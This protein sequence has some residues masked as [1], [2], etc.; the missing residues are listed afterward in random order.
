MR[1]H[2]SA[3]LLVSLWLSACGAGPP[4]AADVPAPPSPAAHAEVAAPVAEPSTPAP[5]AEVRPAAAQSAEPAPSEPSRLYPPGIVPDNDHV[6]ERKI[7]PTSALQH[8]DECT[9]D[10]SSCPIEIGVLGFHTDGRVATIVARELPTCGEDLPAGLAGRVARQS[11]FDR[12][13]KTA[14]TPGRTKAA[15]FVAD[16]ARE[17]F[18]PPADIVAFVGEEP[19][20]IRGVTSLIGLKAPL[21]GWMVHAQD[22]PAPTIRLVDPLN[23]TAHV[24]GE[25]PGRGQP[26]LVQVVLNPE[27]SHLFV[28]VSYSDGSHCGVDPASIHRFPLPAAASP[29]AP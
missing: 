28:T 2:S 6:S 13:P 5:P 1:D 3:S 9:R 26:S 23:R 16:R 12:G 10:P 14:L 15:A 25:L 7:P 20:G 11:A 22:D 17:G 4:S 21:A 8:V 24:L 19:S 29:T 27:G 18:T